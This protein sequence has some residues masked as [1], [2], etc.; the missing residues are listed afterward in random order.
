MV[1]VEAERKTEVLAEHEVV[2][3]GGGPA[4]TMCWTA[5]T[6]AMPSA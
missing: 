3:L 5:S 1:V 4:R 2:V 6:S